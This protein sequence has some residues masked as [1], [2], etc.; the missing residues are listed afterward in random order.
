MLNDARAYSFPL[1]TR[2][3]AECLLSGYCLIVLCRTILLLRH[4]LK[5][6]T[7]SES[8]TFFVVF[9]WVSLSFCFEICFRTLLLSFFVFLVFV[10][11]LFSFWRCLG[12][13]INKKPFLSHL[14]ASSFTWYKIRID[15]STYT[16]A[17]KNV[18][19]LKM[20]ILLYLKL[21]WWL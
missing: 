5:Y 14:E 10:T 6:E 18:L 7:W 13:L 9:G 4:K 11:F 19:L 17:Q 2:R 20:P 12:H 21:S 15:I 8:F 16:W 1:P 3:G